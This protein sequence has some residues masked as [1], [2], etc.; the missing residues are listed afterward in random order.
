MSEQHDSHIY[1]WHRIQVG[2]DLIEK[3]V[4]MLPPEGDMFSVQD[5]VSWLRAMEST[6]RLTH[7]VP[8]KPIE[9]HAV[10]H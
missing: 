2:R 6:I 8:G 5:R 9:I 4:S 1:R 10:E 7:N 3:L